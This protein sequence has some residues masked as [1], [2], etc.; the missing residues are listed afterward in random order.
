M[1][2]AQGANARIIYESESA[3]G[4]TPVAG[5]A[6]VLPFIS[7]TLDQSRGL[8]QTNIIRA[9]RQPTKPTRGNKD[10]TGSIN[11]ELNPYM[12]TILKHIMGSVNTTGAGPYTHTI[13]IGTLPVSLCI[14]KGFT[15]IAQYFL[16]NGCRIN[17]AALEINS[18]GYVPFSIDIRGKKETVAGAAFDATPTDLGHLPFEGFE[19]TLQEGWGAFAIATKVTMEILNNLDGGNYVIG[20]AGERRAL[21][22]GAAVVQGVITALFE[23]LTLYNKAVNFTESSL[24]ITLTRGTGV[25]GAGNESLEIFAPELVYKQKSPPISGPQGVLVEMN[26]VG[27]YD[28]AAEAAAL[29]M[30]L[31]NTQ[32]TL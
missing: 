4:T 12:G 31:K 14:E 1:A 19:A 3:Y 16:Y 17:K 18:D 2:Q 13:K 24:K 10:V 32:V 26:Y 6:I 29:Q 30:V 7:E 8:N 9:S 27:F 20:G 28:N 15:D 11:M 25:G 22:A 21:P 23:D 5:A